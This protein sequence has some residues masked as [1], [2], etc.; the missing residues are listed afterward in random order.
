MSLVYVDHDGEE[1]VY[2]GKEFPG[3]AST[4]AAGSIRLDGKLLT[5]DGNG[6]L[7]IAEATKDMSGLLSRADKAKLDNLRNATTG[8][9]GLMSASDKAKLDGIAP[10]AN[11]TTITNNL[12]T[13]TPGTCLDAVQ[14]KALK[15]SVDTCFQSVSDG[16][17]LVANAITDMGVPT[18]A[19]DAFA[20]IAEHIRQIE[21]GIEY[22]HK[23]FL[24]NSNDVIPIDC[25]FAPDLIFVYGNKKATYANLLTYWDRMINYRQTLYSTSNISMS[26][27]SNQLLDY[28]ETGNEKIIA[29]KPTIVMTNPSSWSGYFNSLEFYAFKF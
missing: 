29:F 27:Y 8:V 7:R 24:P 11:K 18:L 4:K 20:T 22:F 3:L 16:K 21:T 6:V 26:I 12:T 1:Y 19:T 2:A 15:D 10:G 9:D 13:A 14:G 23:S 25:G 28:Y 5:A 17:T